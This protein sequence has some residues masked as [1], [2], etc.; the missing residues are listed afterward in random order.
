VILAGEAAQTDFQNDSGSANRFWKECVAMR[1]TLR[2]RMLL[3]VAVVVAVVFFLL[4]APE[5][6][7]GTGTVQDLVAWL[8]LLVGVVVLVALAFA[9]WGL[10][11]RR[12]RSSSQR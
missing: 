5:I 12:S 7:E 6:S 11:S 1:M 8:Q 10:V 3:L 2:P 4:G 9:A